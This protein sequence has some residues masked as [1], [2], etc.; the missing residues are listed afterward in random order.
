MQFERE[1]AIWT[2]HTANEKSAVEMQKYSQGNFMLLNNIL[3]EH[4]K[5]HRNNDAVIAQKKV[6]NMGDEHEKVTNERH[7]FDAPH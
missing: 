6:L 7:S 1:N 3:Y 4:S 5:V 2:W